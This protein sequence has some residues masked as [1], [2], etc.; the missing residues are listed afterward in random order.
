MWPCIKDQEQ[1]V[2]LT[3]GQYTRPIRCPVSPRW[4]AMT[5]TLWSTYADLVSSKGSN[6]PYHGTTRQVLSFPLQKCWNWGS[7]IE[8]PVSGYMGNK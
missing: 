6:S 4:V 8:W 3:P 5:M 1:T 7:E 2:T